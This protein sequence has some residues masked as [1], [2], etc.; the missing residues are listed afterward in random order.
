[1]YYL[2]GVG[3]ALNPTEEL[4]KTGF[5][6]ISAT[7]NNSTYN[8]RSKISEMLSKIKLQSN[9]FSASQ[10]RYV[11]DSTSLEEIRSILTMEQ[12][13]IETLLSTSNQYNKVIDVVKRDLNTIMGQQE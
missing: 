11:M 3:L 12:K 10:D 1:M 13:A 8:F 7:I 5:E 2:F 4:I 9:S 6:N